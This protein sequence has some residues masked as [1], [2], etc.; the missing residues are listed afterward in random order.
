MVAVFSKDP[1]V[2]A[3]DSEYLR[4]ISW[5]F[6]ASGLIFVASSTFQA[7]GHTVPSLVASGARMGL[8]T[9]VALLL[10]RMPGFQLRWMWYLSVA[11]VLV[12]LALAM[13]FLRH[14][15]AQRLRWEHV[16]A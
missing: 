11:M 15:F 10:A 7:M 6:V 14:E 13:W 5:N 4:I 9:V 1:A 2:I 16:G 8:F 3:V 12:Q